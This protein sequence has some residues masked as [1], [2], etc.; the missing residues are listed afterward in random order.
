MGVCFLQH[1]HLTRPPPSPPAKKGNT[2][3]IPT[4]ICI[5]EQPSSQISVRL[6][7]KKP[8]NNKNQHSLYLGV[9]VILTVR[10]VICYVVCANKRKVKSPLFPEWTAKLGTII[11]NHW[12]N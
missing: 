7:L 5:L 10:V 2:F 3:S 4:E 6:R 9:M 8:N 1:Y 12:W 11:I